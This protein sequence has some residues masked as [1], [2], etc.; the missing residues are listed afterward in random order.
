MDM[1]QWTADAADRRNRFSRWHEV[2]CETVFDVPTHSPL[3]KS[4][5]R[6]A[7]GHVGSPGLAASDCAG[8]ETA[9]TQHVAGAPKDCYFMNLQLSGHSR[10]A[11]DGVCITLAPSEIALLD[12][13]RP[14][15]IQ[16]PESISRIIA[17][18]PRE[19]VDRRAPW[20]R[21]H[22][23]CKVMTSDCRY[24][25]LARQHLLHLAAGSQDLSESAASL[26]MDNL[27]NLFTLANM[28]A[29]GAE[30]HK[31][32]VPLDSLLAFCRQNLHEAQLSPHFVAAH[33]GFS[34]RTLHLRFEKL[35]QSFNR[36]LLEARLEACGAALRDPNSAG[37]TISE[38]AYRCG[39]NDLSHFNRTFRAR[40]NTTPRRW[41]AQPEFARAPE[42]PFARPI[43]SSAAGGIELF[44]ES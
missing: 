18:M 32:E 34:V 38:I 1:I 21:Q 23:A 4:S 8:H 40:F 42:Q 35:G 10:I 22:P 5:A 16:L 14:F 19:M 41:R 7:G 33:F 31:R 20:L 13:Q 27:F 29:A 43:R 24:A 6:T 9:R 3:D 25:D 11:Q 15:H 2:V 37:R 39:F 12:G 28:H 36:W 30:G 26:L 44:V 17:C